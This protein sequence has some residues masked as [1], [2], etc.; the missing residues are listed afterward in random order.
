MKRA[1]LVRSAMMFFSGAV[2]LQIAGCMPSV[3][4]VIQ[5]VLLGISAAGSLA[6]LQNI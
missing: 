4:D 2:V 1:R 5:T 6:I 3:V